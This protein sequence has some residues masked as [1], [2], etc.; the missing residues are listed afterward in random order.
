MAANA[1]LLILQAE[2]EPSTSTK[3][4]RSEKAVA[5]IYLKG[6]L[7]ESYVRRPKCIAL[8]SGERRSNS[9][10]ASPRQEGL[11]AR[12]RGG[13]AVAARQNAGAQ[14]RELIAKCFLPTYGKRA[15]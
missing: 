1:N 15:Q 2:G 8:N 10:A 4:I 7:M 14:W 12:S 11:E 13:H 9:S 5:Q 6:N 3:P